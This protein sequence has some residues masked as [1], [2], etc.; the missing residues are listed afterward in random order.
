MILFT[1]DSRLC[2][3][4]CQQ[5][6]GAPKDHGAAQRELP[7]YTLDVGLE[8]LTPPLVPWLVANINQSMHHH[9]AILYIGC[10]GNTN[11]SNQIRDGIDSTSFVSPI[12]D[13]HQHISNII[14][15]QW[16]NHVLSLSFASEIPQLL[17]GSPSIFSWHPGPIPRGLPWESPAPHSPPSGKP[18]RCHWPG[19]DCGANSP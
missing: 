11:T 2:S 12:G 14:E 7:F 18:N 16:T 17:V 3:P 8:T 10:F 15:Y 13:H 1:R 19:V 9:C 6:V 5:E 4:M